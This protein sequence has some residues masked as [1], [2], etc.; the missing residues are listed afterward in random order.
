MWRLDA[1]ETA[2]S[3]QFVNVPRTW[4]DRKKAEYALHHMHVS[5]EGGK[6]G[7]PGHMQDR[8]CE[9]VFFGIK[10]DDCELSLWVEIDWSVNFEFSVG[11]KHIL[12]VRMQK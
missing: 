8:A 10:N 7:P 4:S 9:C 6:D 3:P 2:W 1:F 11:R 12:C 5:E